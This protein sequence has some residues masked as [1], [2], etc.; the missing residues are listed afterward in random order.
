MG[1]GATITAI[2]SAVSRQFG[3]LP[4][5][6]GTAI[7][8]TDCSESNIYLATIELPGGIVLHDVE[9]WDVSLD[10]YAAEVV[11]G[12]DIISRGRLVVENVRGVPTF[13]FSIEY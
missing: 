2:S 1:Y 5:E 8:A 3:V 7:S 12:M 10:S 13:S 4:I 6:E 11:I 9:V